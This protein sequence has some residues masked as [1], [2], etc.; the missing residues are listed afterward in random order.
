MCFSDVLPLQFQYQASI[1]TVFQLSNK[2]LKAFQKALVRRRTARRETLLVF[3]GHNAA[4]LQPAPWGTRSVPEGRDAEASELPLRLQLHCPV[5]QPPAP[6]PGEE[7]PRRGH[8]SRRAPGPQYAP[9][10]PPCASPAER[11]PTPGAGGPEVPSSFAPGRG[12]LPAGSPGPGEPPR[13]RPPPARRHSPW[14]PS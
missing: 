12:C 11:R 8:R 10:P 5:L 2:E 13:Q 9:R 14:S 7:K 3:P 1:L 4:A 6:G